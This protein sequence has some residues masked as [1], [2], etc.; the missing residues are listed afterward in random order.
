VIVESRHAFAGPVDRGTSTVH[1]RSGDRGRCPH[2]FGRA[3]R[4]A[5]SSLNHARKRSSVALKPPETH[6]GEIHQGAP[7]IRN[8]HHDRDISAGDAAAPIARPASRM[9]V[10]SNGENGAA[11]T[12]P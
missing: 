6:A 9:P 11:P 7:D 10:R 3:S 2:D 1:L 5:F 12:R 4:F 8:A